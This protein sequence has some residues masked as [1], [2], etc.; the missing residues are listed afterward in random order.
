MDAT[1]KRVIARYQRINHETIQNT[2]AAG[3][4]HI[5]VKMFLDA[6]GDLIAAKKR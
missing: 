6:A 1:T 2:V 3:I 4:H 5:L